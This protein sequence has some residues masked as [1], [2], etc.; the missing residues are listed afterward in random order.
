MSPK[1]TQGVTLHTPGTAAEIQDRLNDATPDELAHCIRLLGMYLALYKRSFGELD[2]SCYA[3]LLGPDAHDLG[4]ADL[5]AAGLDEAGAML[6]LV[7]NE[8]D[9]AASGAATPGRPLN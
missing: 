7:Q 1:T 6:C 8:P 3:G 2:E 5:L 9:R 4:L